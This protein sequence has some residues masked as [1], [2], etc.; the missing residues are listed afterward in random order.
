MV[1]F[2]PLQFGSG[3]I[4]FPAV[5]DGVEQLGPARLFGGVAGQVQLEEASCGERQ[6]KRGGGNAS[7][8]YV[9]K[10]VAAGGN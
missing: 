8:L 5:S 3:E 7:E 4:H 6:L 10:Q 1:V 2:C 9:W